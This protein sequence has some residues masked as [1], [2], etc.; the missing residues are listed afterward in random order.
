[1]PVAHASGNLWRLPAAWTDAADSTD[2]KDLALFSD[3][4]QLVRNEYVE[5][6]G[7]NTDLVGNAINGMLTALDAHSYYMDPKAF[8]D[9]QVQT[10][11]TFGGLGMEL[12]ASR[13]AMTAGAASTRRTTSWCG[14]RR[15]SW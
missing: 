10:R 12:I 11:G 2:S 15:S 6:L 3:A 1:M 5:P 13:S 4:I 9:L 8:G 7:G 14:S